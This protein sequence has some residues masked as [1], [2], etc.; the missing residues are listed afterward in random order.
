MLTTWLTRRNSCRL[1]KNF[2]APWLYWYSNVGIVYRYLCTYIVHTS[3]VGRPHHTQ[4]LHILTN[5][6]YSFIT[7]HIH[8]CVKIFAHKR[9]APFHQWPLGFVII[10]LKHHSFFGIQ[11]YY[12]DSI[13]Y[14]LNCT[15][16]CWQWSKSQKY[17]VASKRFWYFDDSNYTYL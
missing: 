2:S 17:H 14:F 5:V 3:Q 16:L 1:S 13:F 6:S 9:R 10:I 4:T 11:Y 15:V 8:A 12:Y 7:D